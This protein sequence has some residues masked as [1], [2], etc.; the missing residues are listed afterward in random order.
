MPREE[1]NAI[2]EKKILHVSN[3]HLPKPTYM[4]VVCTIN[5]VHRL[6]GQVPTW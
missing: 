4:C 5:T 3:T 2:P 6:Q 1:I